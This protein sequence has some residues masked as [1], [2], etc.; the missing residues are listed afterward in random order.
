VLVLLQWAVKLQAVQHLR[1]KAQ[2][3]LQAQTWVQDQKACQA[4]KNVKAS[5]IVVD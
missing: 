2:K 1:K 3:F 4:E 5:T